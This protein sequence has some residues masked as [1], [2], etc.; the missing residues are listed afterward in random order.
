MY[1]KGVYETT[2]IL[3]GKVVDL[4]HKGLIMTTKYIRNNDLIDEAIVIVNGVKIKCSDIKRFNSFGIVN[5]YHRN[6]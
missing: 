1:E 2:L 3:N 4:G 5:E 6:R